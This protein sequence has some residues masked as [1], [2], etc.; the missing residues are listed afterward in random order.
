[1]NESATTASTAEYK[2]VLAGSASETILAI[3]EG[4]TFRLPRVHIPK[5]TRPAEEITRE[6]RENWNLNTVVVGLFPNGDSHPASAVLEVIDAHVAKADPTLRLCRIEE[7]E[8]ADIDA[9]EQEQIK[10]VLLG[11]NEP[12]GPFSRLGWLKDA[13]EWIQNSLRGRHVDFAAD[14]RQYNFGNT[15]AL[16]RFATRSGPAYWLKATGEPNKHELAVTATL[17]ELFPRYLP[18]LVA[19]R[20]DWN[21]WV[22]EDAG[23]PLGSSQSLAS[24]SRAI[25]SLAELQ[26]QSLDHVTCLGERGCVDQRLANVHSRI[27]ELIAYLEEAMGCQTSTKVLPLPSSRLREIGSMIELAYLK[28]QDLNIPPSLVNNDINL[29]NILDDGSR[30]VFIDWA[31]AGVGNPFLTLHQF[32]QHVVRDGERLEWRSDLRDCYKRKW[33]AALAES[34]I[35]RAFV[36]TPLLMMISYLHGRGDW[37]TSSRRDQPVFQSFARTLARHMDRAAREPELL[38]ALYQ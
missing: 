4:A 19:K 3:P 26:M 7:I 12:S 29:D 27:P 23:N 34:Q 9:R 22:T 31:E 28:M 15:F 17:T 38:E 35:D 8:R 1:M 16:V 6:I 14:F 13:Q 11:T 30:N 32:I 25:E 2:V 10:G 33:L 21:A 36:L 18:P 24:L 37:I 5:W 20:D